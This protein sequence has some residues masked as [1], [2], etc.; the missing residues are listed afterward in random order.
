[1]SS[2]PPPPDGQVGSSFAFIAPGLLIVVALFQLYRAHTVDLRPWKGGGFGMFSSVDDRFL[3]FY[4]VSD[5]A[6]ALVDHRDLDIDRKTR[7]RLRNAPDRLLL[8]DLAS[9]AFARDWVADEA[10]GVP[11][12]TDEVEPFS[13]ADETVVASSEGTDDS[14]EPTA[15]MPNEAQTG[16]APVWARP[17]T[18]EDT[19]RLL[20]GFDHVRAELWKVIYD[21]ENGTVG[22]V[23]IARVVVP[24]RS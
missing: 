24:R 7:T 1:M 18:E 15:G 9:R 8:A 2:A 16:P 23:P 13:L 4:L 14:A 12:G 11:P 20:F 10:V 22:A 6:E 17:A 5:T 3:R 21:A 19:D